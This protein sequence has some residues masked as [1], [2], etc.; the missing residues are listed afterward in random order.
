M[1]SQFVPFCSGLYNPDYVESK[2]AKPFRL[3][4]N[5][6]KSRTGILKIFQMV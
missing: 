3:N 2:F 5:F 4:K 1:S 6:F